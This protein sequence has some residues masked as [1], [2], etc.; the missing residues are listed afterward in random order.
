MKLRYETIQS[1]YGR[2]SVYVRDIW[3]RINFI[4]KGNTV[5]I[6]GCDAT[7]PI[8]QYFHRDLVSPPT[9]QKHYFSSFVSFSI[10]L[11]PCVSNVI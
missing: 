2:A 4:G 6:S 3:E 8:C 1:K 11:C 5:A 7:K 10:T 9:T